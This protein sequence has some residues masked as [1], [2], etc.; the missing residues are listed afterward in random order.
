LSASPDYKNALSFW[1]VQASKLEKSI[2]TDVSTIFSYAFSPNGRFLAFAGDGLTEDAAGNLVDPVYYLN[3]QT[4]AYKMFLLPESDFIH[5]LAFSPNGTTLAVGGNS[6]IRFWD[7]VTNKPLPSIDPCPDQYCLG[8]Y[9]D[10]LAYSPDGKMLAVG[11]DSGLIRVFDVQIA[12]DLGTLGGD[13]GAVSSLAFSPDSRLLASG[14]RGTSVRLW[15]LR[16]MHLIATLT[17][18]TDNVIRVTFSPDGKLLASA[19]TDGTVILW[20]IPSHSQ[21]LMRSTSRSIF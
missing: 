7:V 10:S 8:V 17:S 3:L 14:G 9:L 15:D 18:H 4:Y 19:S 11:G 2:D 20:G 5:A 21:I 6:I 12:K 1:D 13:F 16:S